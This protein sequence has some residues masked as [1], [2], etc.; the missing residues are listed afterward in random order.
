MGEWRNWLKQCQCLTCPTELG[1]VATG[2]TRKADSG[3]SLQPGF[4]YPSWRPELTAELTGDHGPSTRLVET[5]ARHQSP[6][7]PSTRAVNSGSGNRALS[8]LMGSWAKSWEFN[9]P[10]PRQFTHWIVYP[11]ISQVWV[12]TKQ[13]CLLRSAPT[14]KNYGAT[15]SEYGGKTW[16]SG[17][18]T[19]WQC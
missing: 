8:C 19:T 13:F 2:E 4:H 6:G 14:L 9:S 15:A 17:V 18:M 7:H 16:Q 3:V 11:R 10:N 1:S 12:Q 5:H